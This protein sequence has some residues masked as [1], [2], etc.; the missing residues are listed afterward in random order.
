[1]KKIM[2]LGSGGMLGHMVYYYLKSL[3]KYKMVDA[4]YPQKLHEGSKLL[5]V[6]NKTVLEEFIVTERPDVVVNCIGILLKGSKDD[7]SNAIYLNALLPHQLSKIL[8]P[9]G[10]KLIHIS[11]DCVFSG[12]KGEYLETD[13][14]DA[15]DTYGLSK[16]L[17]E[18]DNDHD[19]T[20]RTSIVG[21][22]LKEKGEGLFHWFMNQTGTINGFTKMKWAGVTTLELAKAINA[23]VDQKITGLIH[24]TNGIPVSKFEM[25]SLFKEIWNRNN[26]TINAVEGK[27]ADK[28]LKSNRTDFHYSVPA[29]KEMFEEQCNWM[30]AHPDL[31]A[32]YLTEQ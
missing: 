12:N 28:S 16:A 13:L 11:T 15:R 17:G 9:L 8:R 14:K 10:G 20:F 18:I 30:V 27:F 25:V 6:T 21:P 3:D 22:E 23:V 4:S 5:D 1:M 29:Y 32:Q 19:L 31:Y 24:I 7:P 26:I 2:V